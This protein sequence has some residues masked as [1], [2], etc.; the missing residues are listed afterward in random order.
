MKRKYVLGDSTMSSPG[1]IARWSWLFVRISI[2]VFSSLV[3]HRNVHYPPHKHRGVTTHLIV[4]GELTIT[5]PED[6]AP[7]KET[8]GPGGRFD[9]DANR[10]HEVWIGKEGCTYVIGE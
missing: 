1:Q 10:V 3:L 8:L 2:T 6:E 4:R 5:Y 7:T 9:V